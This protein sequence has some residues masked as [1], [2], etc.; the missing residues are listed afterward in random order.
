MAIDDL[1]LRDLLDQSQDLHSD[2]MTTSRSS[3]D[4]LVELGHEERTYDS[5]V[6]APVDEATRRSTLLGK[7]IAVSA[8]EARLEGVAVALD[9][10]GQLFLRAPDGTVR[11]LTA[12]EVSIIPATS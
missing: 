5:G 3:L 10:E 9:S 1:R 7:R 11:T 6:L 12:G 8:G 2:A 4:E